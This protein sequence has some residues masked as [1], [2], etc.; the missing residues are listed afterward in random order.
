VSGDGGL[1]PLGRLH[2]RD[3]LGGQNH[4]AVYLEP[5]HRDSGLIGFFEAACGGDIQG[6]IFW[7]CCELAKLGNEKTLIRW[8]PYRV[9]E[10]MIPFEDG[11]WDRKAVPKPFEG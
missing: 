9:D 2:R 7:G 6:K 3:D 8:F 4:F 1:L 10:K 5:G 11:K